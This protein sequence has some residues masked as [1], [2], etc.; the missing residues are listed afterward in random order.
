MNRRGFLR[1]SLGLL[2]APAIVR[3]ASIMPVQASGDVL[4][5]ATVQRT[6]DFLRMMGAQVN[7]VNAT[8]RVMWIGHVTAIT[9]VRLPLRF[10]PLTETA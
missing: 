1:A 6:V 8:G 2:A 5:I 10:L 7:F 4:N 3:V 9:T